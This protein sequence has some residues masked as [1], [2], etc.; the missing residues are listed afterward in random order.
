[1]ALVFICPV[2]PVEPVGY[3]LYL[4]GDPALYLYGDPA[5]AEPIVALA[6]TPDREPEAEP[7]AEL[8]APK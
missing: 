1:M 2:D 8:E 3:A 6:S 7:K 4:H 5:A